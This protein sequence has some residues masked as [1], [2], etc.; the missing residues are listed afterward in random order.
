MN[1]KKNRIL[2]YDVLRI[3]GAAF[4]LLTHI[5]AYI[6]IYYENG[7]HDEWISGNVIQL[8]VYAANP[9]FVMLSGALLLQEKRSNEGFA[10]YKRSLVPIVIL[11]IG[12]VVFYAFFYAVILPL[13]ENRTPDFQIFLN[14]CFQL[15]GSDYPHL[16]YLYMLIGLYLIIPILRIFA[17]KENIQYIL[18]FILI[19]VIAQFIP[20]F[21]TPLCPNES[22]KPGGFVKLFYLQPFMGY[23]TYLL[24][25]WLIVNYELKKQVRIGLYFLAVLF[26]IINFIGL[27]SGFIVRDAI[28]NALSIASLIW[29]AAV[30]IAIYYLFRDK[31]TRNRI[32]GEVAKLSFGV[33]ALHILFLELFVRFILPYERFV[34]QVPVLYIAVAFFCVGG[35]SLLVSFFLSRIRGLNGI[36]RYK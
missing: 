25:G 7:T 24:L 13:L 32:A 22:F 3:V 33:Y 35:V 5:S 21:I 34:P 9:I 19:S 11:T 26:G 2:S 17:K 29:G 23:T 20:E 8:L 6:I 15:K 36:I 1:D 14:Y 28:F 10:F 18:I 27:K 12:W 16:W 4:V 30:F 31:E